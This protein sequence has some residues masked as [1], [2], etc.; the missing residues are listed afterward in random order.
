ML[1]APGPFRPPSGG[2]YLGPPCK[3]ALAMGPPALG[4]A[5]GGSLSS[6]PPQ[7]VGRGSPANVACYNKGVGGHGSH[8]SAEEGAQTKFRVEGPGVEG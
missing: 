3:T 5:E 2:G 6:P 7:P 8:G 4:G 1:A